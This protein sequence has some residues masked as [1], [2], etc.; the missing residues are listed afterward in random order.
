MEGSEVSKMSQYMDEV[1]N[2]GPLF[3]AGFV[4]AILTKATRNAYLEHT[5]KQKI[6]KAL[7]DAMVTGMLAAGVA[8]VLPM[9]VDNVSPAIEFG[10]A[11]LVGRFGNSLIETLLKAKFNFVVLD[12]K[13]PED[14]EKLHA[15]M[16]DE[17]RMEHVNRCP[18]SQEHIQKCRNQDCENCEVHN[19]GDSNTV[20]DSNT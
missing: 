1:M 11:V 2:Y 18:F 4:V 3:C 10:V 15:K 17:D 20:S 13:H 14:L 7:F 19:G 6:I 5:T 9:L 8:M 16:S 12:P